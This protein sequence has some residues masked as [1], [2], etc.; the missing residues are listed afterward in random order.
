MQFNVSFL[1]AYGAAFLLMFARIGT[2]LMLLPG[3]GEMS[4][5]SRIRLTIALLLTLDRHYLVATGAPGA[6]KA[7]VGL[8]GPYDFLPFDAASA[9]DA[10]GR[11]PDPQATQPIHFVRADAP[12]NG[13]GGAQRRCARVRHTSAERLRHAAGQM[14]WRWC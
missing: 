13:G 5:P 1:P 4:V 12:P 6:I 9:I 8:A 2:M 11:Y 10:F 3:L 14:V 7:A